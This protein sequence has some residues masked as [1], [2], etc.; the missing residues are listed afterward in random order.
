MDVIELDRRCLKMLGVNRRP[1]KSFFFPAK[2]R[3]YKSWYQDDSL[4]SQYGVET[5]RPQGKNP[6]D[7]FFSLAKTCQVALFHN[8]INPIG[9]ELWLRVGISNVRRLLS[10]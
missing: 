6:S 10:D 3:E 8:T 1:D 9:A 5:A 2:F 7:D 4:V